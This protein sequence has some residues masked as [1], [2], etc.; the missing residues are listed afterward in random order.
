MSYLGYKFLQ[1]LQ[2]SGLFDGVETSLDINLHKVQ[3]GPSSVNT[4][5]TFS[6]LKYIQRS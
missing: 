3:L 4:S 2:E 5:I 6:L 1:D